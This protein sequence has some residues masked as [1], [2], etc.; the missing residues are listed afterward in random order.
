MSWSSRGRSGSGGSAGNLARTRSR[1]SCAVTGWDPPTPLEREAERV[2]DRQVA[3]VQLVRPGQGSFP[4]QRRRQPQQPAVAERRRGWQL[5]RGGAGPV[6]LQPLRG[7]R[8]GH[9]RL[10]GGPGLRD[11]I[12]G[13]PAERLGRVEQRGI[14]GEQRDP[15]V[16]A[17]GD[18]LLVARVGPAQRLRPV[19]WP[20]AA[21][22][23]RP[24]R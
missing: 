20:R 23:R 2:G 7:A 14:G 12:I 21:A 19:Q 10:A 18:D 4:G 9:Q 15:A 6:V 22:R 1:I 3:V 5:S 8:G 17:A 13:G 11:E 24:A 16:P